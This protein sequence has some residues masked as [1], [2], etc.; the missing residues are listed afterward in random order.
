MT[1][2]QELLNRLP[3]RFN[4]F[5]YYQVIVGKITENQTANPDIAI[6]SCKSLVEGI[7]KSILKHTDKTYRD[8][9]RPTEE[10]APLFKKAVN[11]LAG[12]GANIEEK[13]TKAVGNFVHQLGSVR[14]ERGDISHGKSAPKLIK[15]TPHFASLV[16][17]AT[18]GLSSFLLHELFA[19]DLSD[20]IPLEYADNPDFNDSLD[21]LYPI[22]GRLSY[23]RAL[24]DQD[25]VAYEEQL[26]DFK[27]EQ[28][29]LREEEMRAD[30]YMDYVIDM[31]AE[32]SP[33]ED[34]PDP[35][36]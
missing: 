21:D 23:S 14:N 18:D 20:V 27:A 5:D 11:A 17:Q 22:Q 4:D 36:E 12:R 24:F 19:L 7:S 32:P 10:L 6:E 13:F 15:S 2:T 35:E 1:L 9:Q 28:E 25:F 30:A 31:K 29:E 3:T 33:D 8:N 34:A 26:E 16:V